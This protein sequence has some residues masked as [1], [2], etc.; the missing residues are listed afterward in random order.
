MMEDT[1]QSP[2]TAA[3]ATADL[4]EAAK[5]VSTAASDAGQAVVAIAAEAHDEAKGVF[6]SLV[7]KL[8]NFEHALAADAVAELDKLKA[9]LHL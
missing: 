8:E 6:A 3:P 4:N 9:L 7:S 2:E 1:T 5:D